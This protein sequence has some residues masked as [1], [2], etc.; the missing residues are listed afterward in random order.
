MRVD[1]IRNEESEATGRAYGLRCG[2]KRA[3]SAQFVPLV[4]LLCALVCGVLL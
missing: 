4:G 2:G 3:T 1:A